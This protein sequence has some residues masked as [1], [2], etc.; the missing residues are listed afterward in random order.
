MKITCIAASLL[1]TTTTAWSAGPPPT[2]TLR[3]S[4]RA[5]FTIADARVLATATPNARAFVENFGATLDTAIRSQTAT[6][7]NIAVTANDEKHGTTEVGMY[8][9]S[10]KTGNVT[11]DDMEPAEDDSTAAIRNKLLAR[12]CATAK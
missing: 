2:S 6:T 7:A 12:H 9:V 8:I 4:C 1:V 3:T 10:L 11:D 5:S